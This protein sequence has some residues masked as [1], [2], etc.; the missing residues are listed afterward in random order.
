MKRQTF[1]CE[2]GSD[3]WRTLR[4]GLIT[5]SN[6]GALLAEG[7]GKMYETLIH[8]VAAEI[9]TG[10]PQ[11]THTNDYMERGKAWEPE[12][13]SLY[14]LKHSCDPELVG[15]IRWGRTGCS[16]D[17]LVGKNG[18]LQIKTEKAEL[19]IK[20]ILRDDFPP[21]HKAQTQGELMVS[22]REWLDLA[23]YSRKMPLFCKR[24]VRDEPY[25]KRLGSKLKQA[26]EEIDIIVR[27]LRAR[28]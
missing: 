12:A 2:Q 17:A 28:M 5:A 21:K 27:R 19:L 24:V 20:T 3:E 6:Y 11:E 14:A 23:I 25:I 10:E 7:D 16:P 18:L 13:R 4:C 8:R 15:F 9:F 22:D 26:N 1:T